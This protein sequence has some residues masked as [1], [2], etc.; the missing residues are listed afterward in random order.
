MTPALSLYLDLWRVLAAVQVVLFHVSRIDATGYGAG[1]SNAWGHEAVVV[2]F[3]LSGFVISHAANTSDRTFARF[4][5]SRISRLYSVVIPCLLLTVVCDGIG[6]HLAPEIYD[7]VDIKNNTSA[8]LA[9]VLFSLLMLSESWVSVRFFSN[10]PFWSLC[11]EFWYYVMFGFCVYF[12]GRKR[13][14]LVVAAAVISGPHIVLLF[15]VWLLGVAACRA[16]SRALWWPGARWL[17][18]VQFVVVG[19]IYYA[20]DL[21]I[22]CA[23]PA[24]WL[25]EAYGHNLGWSMYV[26]SDTMIG[27]SF[28][29]HLVAV[30]HFEKSIHRVLERSASVIRWLA[31]RSFTLYLLHQP[32]AF[33]LTAV[34]LQVTDGPW[35]T[36]VIVVGTFG[37]PLLLA[38][39]IEAQRHRLRPLVERLQHQLFNSPTATGP[40]GVR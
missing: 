31:A 25:L 21:R 11:Y 35:R 18:L 14:L 3:V 37:L 15:P 39:L 36:V 22:V 29:L 8:P 16:S 9:R 27:L 40:H 24:S 17:A 38:P 33:V 10:V 6:L 20:F 7:V 32:L 19:F 34:M 12:T 5:S 2:F 26:I 23:Q 28:A 13:V 30:K 4:A 1:V